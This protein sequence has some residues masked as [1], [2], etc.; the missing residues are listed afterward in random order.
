MA[1]L[2]AQTLKNPPTMLDT[3]FDPWVGKI[4]WR[5]AWQPTPVFLPGEF[6]EQRSLEDYSSWDHKESDMTEYV[7][8]YIYVCVCV[9]V[10]IYVC[11]EYF[12]QRYN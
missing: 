1:S 2:V 3:G 10:Y 6:H 11:S 5:K 7:C 9:C 12:L 4:P 8:T